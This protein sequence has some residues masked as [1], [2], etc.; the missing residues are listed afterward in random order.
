MWVSLYQLL[1]RHHDSQFE[2]NRPGL[3]RAI[4]FKGYLYLYL[5]ASSLQP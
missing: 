4:A 5:V 2:D 1:I 3:L